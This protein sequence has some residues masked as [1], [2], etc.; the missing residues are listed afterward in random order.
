MVFDSGFGLVRQFLNS[1]QPMKTG[2][3]TKHWFSFALVL[4]DELEKVVSRFTGD[5]P[6]FSGYST[7]ATHLSGTV[8]V[9]DPEVPGMNV[10]A[11]ENTFESNLLP[12]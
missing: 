1:R 10:L 9:V 2:K 6:V 4:P 12:H 3:S 8:K 7:V 5:P 11:R